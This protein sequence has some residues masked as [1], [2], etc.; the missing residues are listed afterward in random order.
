[1]TPVAVQAQRAASKGLSHLDDVLDAAGVDLVARL[2]EG[3][4][5]DLVRLLQRVHAA[6]RAQVPQLRTRSQTRHSVYRRDLVRLLQR[7]H[8]ALRAQVP[9]L[10]IRGHTT[11]VSA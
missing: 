1:M 8:A 10:R 4:R 2:G 7:V 5:R 3:H 9:Q 6:L 11:G